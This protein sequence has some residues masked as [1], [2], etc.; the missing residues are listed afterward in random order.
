MYRRL[1]TKQR[2]QRARKL[3]AMKRG[4]ERAALARQIEVPWEIFT[5]YTALLAS[6]CASSVDW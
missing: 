2:E 6:M 3:E 1:S 5:Y 4:R